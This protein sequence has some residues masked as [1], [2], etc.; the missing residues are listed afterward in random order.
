MIADDAVM[1]GAWRYE[2]MD[3]VTWGKQQFTSVLTCVCRS[4]WWTP[5]ALPVP[6]GVSGSRGSVAQW[7]SGSVAQWVRPWDQR[8]SKRSRI[9]TASHQQLGVI[10]SS[11]CTHLHSWERRDQADVPLRSPRLLST[12]KLLWHISYENRWKFVS[13][14]A[15]RC[16]P[17]DTA[18]QR[19]H[20]SIET[21][22]LNIGLD[23]HMWET[24]W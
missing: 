22:F 11:I 20:A 15:S 2:D 19:P 9:R 5:E 6:A 16:A 23:I 21:S 10:L 1:S 8:A 3:M 24:S 12:D 18:A 4:T 17:S 7:L 14:P 13:G